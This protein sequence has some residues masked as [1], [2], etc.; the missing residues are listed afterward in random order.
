MNI[1]YATALIFAIVLLIFAMFTRKKMTFSNFSIGNKKL[2]LF[3]LFASI[4][5]TFIGPGYSLGFIRKGYETG[6]LFFIIAGAYGLQTILA[7]VFLAPRLQRMK[8]T[9][10]IGDVVGNAHGKLSKLLTGIIAFGLTIAFCSI[11]AKIGGGVLNQFLGISKFT[12]IT[13]IT[14]IVIVY[15]F[16]GGI[17]ASILT[18]TFQFILFILLFLLMFFTLIINVDISTEQLISVAKNKTF[19]GW[20]SLSTLSIIGLFVSFFLGE[21]LVPPYIN[22]AIGAKTSDIS[23]KAFVFSGFFFFIWLLL[24][25]SIGVLSDFSLSTIP[26]DLD[27][28]GIT[29][30]Q[31]YF[32]KGIYGLFIV[33]LIGIIMSTQDSL[34]NSGSTVFVR[35][36]IYP[37][38]E[39]DEKKSLIY[40]KISTII[41]GLFT[42][43]L[44]TYVPSVIEGLLWC[45]SIWAPSILTILVASIV[46]NKHSK[47]GGISSILIG[48]LSTVL[49]KLIE[50]DNN[51]ITLLGTSLSVFSYS[52]IYFVENYERRRKNIA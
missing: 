28:I 48:I 6:F 31:R 29:V 8:N 20:N 1:E 33:A 4:S 14:S 17:K 45:Y 51:I 15:S 39:I 52:I 21:S 47:I 35:D 27:Q 12:S 26:N 41:I 22:R 23:K 16:L 5:A 32:N 43:I 34:I 36:I 40:S 24:M 50:I 44:S 46:L 49:F 37:L 3:I 13:I 2:P 9:Y 18:D 42:I 30:S 38:K 7:G 10:S 11:M 25:L 19:V